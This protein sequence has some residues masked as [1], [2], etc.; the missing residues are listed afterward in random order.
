MKMQ[1]M[2]F[3]AVVLALAG[4][5]ATPAHATLTVNFDGFV[6]V[7]QNLAC[8]GNATI[9]VVTLTSVVLGTVTIQSSGSTS[10]SPIGSLSM[11]LNALP[12]STGAF[13]VKVSDI[14]FNNPT[15][16][17]VMSQSLV[18]L[19]IGGAGGPTATISAVGYFGATNVLFDT[20]G[21]ATG[22]AGPVS[23]GVAAYSTSPTINFGNPYSLTDVI[24][25][26]VTALG[27]GNADNFQVSA[28]LGTIGAIPEPASVV[29]LGGLLLG[30]VGAIRRRVSKQS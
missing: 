6:C 2:A 1:R 28:N 23:L 16:P 18:G 24:H 25:I 30:A 12:S 13:D 14:G 11:T 22:I 4:V 10:V 17:L 19:S 26:D 29:L 7:D 21:P 15:V 20:S 3:V 8:D 5:M 9:G 27:T